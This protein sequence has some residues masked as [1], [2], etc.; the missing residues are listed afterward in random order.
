M[1][2]VRAYLLNEH[3]Y[4]TLFWWFVCERQSIWRRRYIEKRPPPW[5]QDQI[6]RTAR[7]T[8]VYRELDPGTDYLIRN[9]LE[10][11]H[12]DEDKIFNV[13]VYR[14]IGRLETYKRIGFQTVASFDSN[15]FEEV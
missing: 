1:S 2:I 10:T 6:L 7:F 12:G 3:I 13:M 11:S 15:R 14:L 4:K 5:T 9:I 8:N